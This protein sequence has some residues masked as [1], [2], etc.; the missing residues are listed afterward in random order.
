VTRTWKNSTS[1]IFQSA[2]RGVR[3][4]DFYRNQSTVRL[5]APVVG[6]C[7][8]KCC[9]QRRRRTTGAFKEGQITDSDVGRRVLLEHFQAERTAQCDHP[10]IV[11]D[12]GEPSSA[13]DSVFANRVLHKFNFRIAG[14][15]LHK[16]LPGFKES[17]PG[18]C[19]RREDAA[20]FDWNF[21][22]AGSRPRKF[23]ILF[24][25]PGTA[26]I[27]CV[28]CDGAK[29]ARVLFRRR[30]AHQRGILFDLPWRWV[31]GVSGGHH[32]HSDE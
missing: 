7:R 20:C 15:E 4:A 12:T 6:V 25:R 8:P 11:S 10:L 30:H 26:Y 3:S 31:S 23:G 9:F 27:C 16:I 13:R 5:F 21:D 17:W 24:N 1:G 22:S 2:V 19:S 32:D 29:L 28:G 14:I 18:W